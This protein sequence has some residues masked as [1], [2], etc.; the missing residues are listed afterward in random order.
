MW[1]VTEKVNT[2]VLILHFR[3]GFPFVAIKLCEIRTK[4]KLNCIKLE[5]G[6]FISVI[7]LLSTLSYIKFNPGLMDR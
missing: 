7:L 5:D 6:K 2:F 3:Q 4:V 1:T